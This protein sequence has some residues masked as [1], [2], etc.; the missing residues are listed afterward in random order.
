[1]TDAEIIFKP[2]YSG[3]AAFTLWFWPI[4]A[5]GFIYFS[6]ESV[7]SGAYFSLGLLALMF[8]VAAFSPPFMYFRALVF[9]ENLVVKRYLLPD[10]VIAYDKITSFQYFSLRTANTRV[11]LNNLN[12]KSFAE[13]DQIVNRMIKAGK[14]KLRPRI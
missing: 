14:I 6:F 7:R 13:L 5:I 8:G 9:G 1:M 3:R 12:P 4:S 2:R 11:A 10:L